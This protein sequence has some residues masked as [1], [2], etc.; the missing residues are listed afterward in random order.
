MI[1]SPGRSVDHSTGGN[2]HP[3]GPTTV[4]T[5]QVALCAPGQRSQRGALRTVWRRS[6]H[7]VEGPAE[8]IGCH[9]AGGTGSD[10]DTQG[11]ERL[12]VELHG[13]PGTPDGT[14]DRQIGAF[15][16]QPGVEQGR[17]LSVDG[18]NGKACDL[19][20]RVSGDRS[21]HTCGTEDGRGGAIA[22]VEGGRVDLVAGN[23]SANWC[24]HEMGPLAKRPGSDEC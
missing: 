17:H 13:H 20:D 14:R 9:D 5:G 19:G 22:D 15:A 24:G 11:Q 16:Q 7:H 10:V 6:F 21:T 8:Q 4:P 1:H 3:Q 12:V 23:G 2:S 18:S